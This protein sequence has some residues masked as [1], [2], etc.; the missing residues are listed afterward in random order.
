MLNHKRFIVNKY[1]YFLTSANYNGYLETK[2]KIRINGKTPK[3][4]QRLLENSGIN[5][6]HEEV[7]MLN[8]L[9]TLLAIVTYRFPDQLKALLICSNK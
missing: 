7:S 5:T 6:M 2:Y 4:T 1:Y 3:H 8:M 9:N